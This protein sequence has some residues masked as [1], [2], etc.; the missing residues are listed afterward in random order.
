MQ[1][2]IPAERQRCLVVRA[3]AAGRDVVC[4]QHELQLDVQMISGKKPDNVTQGLSRGGARKKVR[5]A[6][7]REWAEA[8]ANAG[9]GI[10]DRVAD[11]GAE[12]ELIGLAPLLAKRALGAGVNVVPAAGEL[13]HG[14]V[15]VEVIRDELFERRRGPLVRRQQSSVIQQ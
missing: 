10:I 4:L 15:D 13:Y 5:V 9:L 1:P 12:P 8:N 2:R 14:C 11:H 7:A 6:L 3:E